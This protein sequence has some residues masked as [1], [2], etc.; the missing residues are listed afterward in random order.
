MLIMSDFESQIAANV[1]NCALRRFNDDD[2]STNCYVMT[3]SSM[4]LDLF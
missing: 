2:I 1:L 3:Q 4:L